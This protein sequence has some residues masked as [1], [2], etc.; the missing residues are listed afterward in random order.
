[1][2]DATE[3]TDMK[4]SRGSFGQINTTGKKFRGFKT[5]MYI[6]TTDKKPERPRKFDQNDLKKFLTDAKLKLSDNAIKSIGHLLRQSK[7]IQIAP[8]S[9]QLF[10]SD[11]KLLQE[12]FATTDLSVDQATVILHLE[13]NCIAISRKVLRWTK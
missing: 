4:I 13:L 9:F 5:S 12:N 7:T 3:T 6:V 2:A 1:M 8:Y 11:R 10:V